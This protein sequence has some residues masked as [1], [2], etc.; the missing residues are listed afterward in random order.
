MAFKC[1]WPTGTGKCG[2]P[3]G[4]GRVMAEHGLIFATSMFGLMVGSI[5][6][7]IQMG[8]IIG[9]VCCSTRSSCVR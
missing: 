3:T 5:G 7:M 2:W 1:G 8:F 9:C 4:T 6:I